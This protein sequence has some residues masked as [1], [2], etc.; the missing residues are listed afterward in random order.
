MKNMVRRIM[1]ITMVMLVFAITLAGCTGKNGNDTEVEQ[2][3]NTGMGRYMEEDLPLPEG[4]SH[5]MAFCEKEDKSISVAV[6][7]E[8]QG[9]FGIWNSKDTGKNWVKEMDFTEAFPQNERQGIGA[10]ALC[11]TGEAAC[12]MDDYSEF[13]TNPD[14][15]TLKKTY[16]VLGTGEKAVPLPLKLE[17]KTYLTSWEYT[18]EGQL[19]GTGSDNKIYLIDG[20]TGAIIKTFEIPG[21]FIVDSTVIG[22]TLV[23]V[24]P[25]EVLLFELTTGERLKKDMVLNDEMIK[26]GTKLEYTGMNTSAV[27]VAGAEDQKSIYFCTRDGIF[28]HAING[29]V[30]EEL[31]D[32]R[33]SSLSNPS[34]GLS[35][36]TAMKDGSFVVGGEDEKGNSILYKYTYHKDISAMPKNLVKVYSL[37]DN[38]EIRQVIAMFRKKNPDIAVLLETGIG[39]ENGVTVSDAIR[40]L[41]TNIMAGKGP[42]LMVLDG[43]PVKNYIEK[44]MLEDLS[45]LLKPITS[46]DGIIEKITETFTKEGKIYAMPTRFSI[47]VIQGDQAV[48]DTINDLKSLADAAEQLKKVDGKKR[49][50][51]EGFR[52]ALAQRL[53]DTSSA[54]WIKEDG[55]IDEAV[56]KEFFTEV[57]RIYEADE[58]KENEKDDQNNYSNSSIFLG[59][60]SLLM[61]YYAGSISLNF[62]PLSSMNAFAGVTSANKGLPCSSTF[63]VLHGQAKNLFI[64][65]T[66]IGISTKAQNKESAEKF[67]SYLLGKEAQSVSQGCGF[68]V[69]IAALEHVCEDNLF[70]EGAASL[71][72]SNEEGVITQLNVEWPTNEEVQSLKEYLKAVETPANTDKVLKDTI[73]EVLHQCLKGEYTVDQAVKEVM[74]KVNLYLS[75]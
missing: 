61:D 52:L 15:G 14:N 46:Q 72:T 70:A 11:P 38:Q 62:G 57:K 49:I 7:G 50:T 26:G 66:I 21:T 51:P 56:L 48:L 29:N 22:N 40:T 4:A 27:L 32:G 54:A 19:L 59:I 71:M 30:V 9:V 17:G 37:E 28:S 47:P 68:P 2:S 65:E 75:E 39:G 12:M 42:D 64:P 35:S 3:E 58:H 6:M 31:A 13:E 20:S 25:Q 18:K 45:F 73:L 74:K 53:Y 69:N 60:G 24:A 67:V 41:N 44:G 8:K 5:M 43:I 16:W 33:L 36:L 55:T 63:K 10:V 23:A 1:C 34:M